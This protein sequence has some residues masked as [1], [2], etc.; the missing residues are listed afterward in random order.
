[1]GQILPFSIICAR[2]NS[3]F[4]SLVNKLEVASLVH[5]AGCKRSFCLFVTVGQYTGCEALVYYGKWF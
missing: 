5:F 1:M 4:V 3:E 2:M